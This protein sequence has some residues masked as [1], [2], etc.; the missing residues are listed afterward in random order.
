[1]AR[2]WNFDLFT[3]LRAGTARGGSCRI[4]EELGVDNK[5]IS[6]VRRGDVGFKS[7]DVGNAREPPATRSLDSSPG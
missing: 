2:N 3:I 6:F 4:D 5:V 1:M 7:L